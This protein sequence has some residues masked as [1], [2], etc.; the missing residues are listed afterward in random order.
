MSRT[1]PRDDLP[2]KKLT[3]FSRM[4]IIG[5][6]HSLWRYPVKS[7]RGEELD[8]AFVG[9]G[10]I[11]GDRR[12][13]FRSSANREDFPYFTGRDQ[14]QMLRYRPRFR[15]AGDDITGDALVDVE[16]PEGEQFA[17]DDPALIERLRRNVGAEHHVTLMRSDR[18]LAD[19]FPVSMISVQTADTLG[20]ET[21]LECDPRRFR[22]NIYLN[23]AS[24]SGFAENELVGRSVRLGTEVV[25]RVIKRDSR[26]MMITLHP[27][28]AERSPAIF[29]QVAQAHSGT[30]GVYGDVV[31][32]GLIRKGDAVELLPPVP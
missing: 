21:A 1:R 2:G 15:Q 11:R 28:T 5:V 30:A 18:A 19:A 23:L 10:G 22:A 3:A 20:Q 27:D 29:K 6:I 12:F 24:Q 13:A 26:C 32:E 7:M 17:V 25:V 9:F 14:R 4:S 16:T 8:E 31:R